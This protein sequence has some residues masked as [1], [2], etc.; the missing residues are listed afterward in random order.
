MSNNKDNSDSVGLIIIVVTTIIF[1]SLKLT[2]T[3]DWSWYW[4][5]SPILSVIALLIFLGIVAYIYEF[6]LRKK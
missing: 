5:F 1:I 3:I 2:N 6:F 4:V